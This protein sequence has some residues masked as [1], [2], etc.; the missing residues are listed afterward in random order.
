MKTDRDDAS[1]AAQS[2]DG[3]V[4]TLAQRF[5][6]VVNGDAQG[7][8]DSRRRMDPL[9]LARAVQQ[10][11]DHAREFERRSRKRARLAA[12]HDRARYLARSALLSVIVEYFGQF[13]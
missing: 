8:K 7:L 11:A 5:E 2:I 12:M 1:G 9:A 3:A 13:R 4:Q 10:T 6:F